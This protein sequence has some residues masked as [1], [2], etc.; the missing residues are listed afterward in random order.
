MQH[1]VQ[2][3]QVDAGPQVAQRLAAERGQ[4][5]LA[6]AQVVDLE[7]ERDAQRGRGPCRARP[8]AARRQFD[9]DAARVQ[10]GSSRGAPSRPSTAR[11]PACRPRHPASVRTTRPPP[12]RTTS[13]RAAE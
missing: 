13:M 9:V 5:Q 10:P 11:V 1:P 4:V 3:A 8:V 7:L 2:V 12:G 6:D